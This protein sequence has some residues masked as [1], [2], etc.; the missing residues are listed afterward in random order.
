MPDV[1][2]LIQSSA[3]LLAFA[4]ALSATVPA[5]RSSPRR[6]PAAPVT[7]SVSGTK[8]SSAHGDSADNMISTVPAINPETPACLTLAAIAAPP[9]ESTATIANFE[10]IKAI[11]IST[12]RTAQIR[13]AGQARA[14]KASGSISTTT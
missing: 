2:R 4:T 13:R 6:A 14:A 1:V 7:I 9:R 8:R 5:E 11:R 12:A 10:R 3:A